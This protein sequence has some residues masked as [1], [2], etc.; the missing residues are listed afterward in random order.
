MKRE[1][2]KKTEKEKMIMK[3]IKKNCIKISRKSMKIKS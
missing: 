1:N 2:Y 3:I